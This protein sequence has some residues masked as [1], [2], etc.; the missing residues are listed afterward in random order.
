ML[1]FFLVVWRNSFFADLGT[2]VPLLFII[3]KWTVLNKTI[4]Q[5]VQSAV[6]QVNEAWW[7]ESLHTM[8]WKSFRPAFWTIRFCLLSRNKRF[9]EVFLSLYF[10]LFS[11]RGCQD[12]DHSFFIVHQSL[13]LIFS[14]YM[15]WIKHTA[16]WLL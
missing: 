16:W 13:V 12:S 10:F 6:V 2:H 5:I 4:M 15:K 3:P 9:R 8:A 7:W 1:I 14:N 11:C